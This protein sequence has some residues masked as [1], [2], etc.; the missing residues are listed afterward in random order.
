MEHYNKTLHKHSILEHV[1]NFRTYMDMF[2]EFEKTQL[3]RLGS[4]SIGGLD[5]SD[6]FQEYMHQRRNAIIDI[7]EETVAHLKFIV[8]HCV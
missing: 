5:E 2:P 1:F 7:G 8:E 3:V 4:L 6:T